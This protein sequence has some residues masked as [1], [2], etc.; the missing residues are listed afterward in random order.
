MNQATIQVLSAV[1][2]LIAGFG[3][4][5]IVTLRVMAGRSP[6]ALRLGQLATSHR[7]WLTFAVSGVAT[8]GSLYFSEVADMVPCRLCWFQRIGMYPIAVVSLIAAIRRDQNAR[9]YAVAL[10]TIGIA[11]S[12]YHYTI[13]WFPSLERGSCGLFGPACAE[14]WFREFG[15]VTLALMA[16]LGFAAIIALNT[17]SFPSPEDEIRPP[18]N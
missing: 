18:S 8:L 10:G 16:L 11:I 7:L 6:A 2:A 5:T 14:I 9:W 12:T 4:V 17:I 1:L 15:F 13:E 3:A